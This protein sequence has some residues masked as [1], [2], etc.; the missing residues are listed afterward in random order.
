[1]HPQPILIEQEFIMTRQWPG[2]K[3]VRMLI[4][5][6]CSWALLS[7]CATLG[8]DE[9][10][11]AEWFTIG[12]EDGSRGYPASRIGDHREACAK[13]GV[14]PDFPRY[15]EG[16]LEGLQEYC[17]PQKGYGLGAAGKQC[18]NI[19]PKDLEA[20]F[21]E[22]YNQGKLVHEARTTVHRQQAG[23]KKLNADLAAVNQKL[24]D[25]ETE[26]VGDRRIGPGRR[27]YLLEEIK[28]L[29]EEQQYLTAEISEQE[30]LLETAT[31]NLREIAAGNPY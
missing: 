25:Y 6:I 16:R 12:Y 21:L 2:K 20:A 18:P 23:L 11:N 1:M 14:T 22:G 29:T 13:H 17:T 28:I 30:A 31:L 10:L 26:L 8:K 4:P 9:C 7:S 15:E 3:V 24:G 19:C 27:R 5:F